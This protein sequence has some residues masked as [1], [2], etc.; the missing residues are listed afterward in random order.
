MKGDFIVK[1]TR[2]IKFDIIRTVA[3]LCVILCHSTEFLYW[4]GAFPSSSSPGRFLSFFLVI[5]RL[6]VPLFFLLS[7]ALLLKKQIETDE[8][9][10]SF[11][12]KNLL[13]LFIAYEIWIILYNLFLWFT[14][15]ST[16]VNFECILKEILLLH[17]VDIPSIWYMF[18]IMQL[19]LFIPFLA[20]IV[21]TF[22]LKSLSVVLIAL[23]FYA[24]V[25]PYVNSL[26]NIFHIEQSLALPWSFMGSIYYLVYLLLGYFITNHKRTRIPTIGIILAGIVC[27]IWSCATHFYNYSNVTSFSGTLWYDLLPVFLTSVCLFLLLNRIDDARVPKKLASYFTYISK[28]SLG[29]FYLHYP[30]LYLITLFVQFF[31]LTL[32]IK[33]L[34]IFLLTT[35]SCVL[36]IH[37][38][39]QIKWIAKY[40]FIIK[41]PTDSS[42]LLTSET[43]E[44]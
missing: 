43:S 28:I 40:V 24:F 35:G 31:V 20:K 23:I 29:L 13:P 18:A 21:K 34:L 44:K 38:L 37:F 15:Y 26:F 27:F 9:V 25:L 8:D 7:G 16:D 14:S 42:K 1:Q 19:Y 30:I 39:S 3:I 10:L 6:G 2:I 22:S 17:Q 11:Y 12:K 5:G 41:E 36:L 32:P 4:T 33:L